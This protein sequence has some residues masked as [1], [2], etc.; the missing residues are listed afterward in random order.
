MNYD[1]M[2][3]LNRERLD[4]RLHEAAAERL[5]QSHRPSRRNAWTWVGAAW[6]RV[7]KPSSGTVA[8]VAQPQA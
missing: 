3:H 7:P 8:G 6:S 2:Q 5:V 4:R 1:T